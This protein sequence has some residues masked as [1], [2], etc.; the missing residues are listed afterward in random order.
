M[1]APCCTVFD[2]AAVATAT[3]AVKAYDA[4]RCDAY[5]TDASGL[6]GERLRLAQVNDHI[7]LP[8]IIS[9]EPLGPAVRHGDDQWFDIVKWFFEQRY[10]RHD[11][12][13]GAIA[14]LIAVVLQE[15]CLHG[16]QIVGISQ[17]LDGGDLFAVVQQRQTET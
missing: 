9:K 16:V 15:G 5:T 4:G 3:E 11:L 7:I 2:C 1:S 10:R 8:E 17:A 12:P 6:A 14:A 13:R